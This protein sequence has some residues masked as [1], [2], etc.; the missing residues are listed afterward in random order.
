[1]WS[2]PILVYFGYPQAH[3]DYALRAVHT[4]LGI[5]EAVEA[6]NTGLESAKGITLAV[7]LGIHTGRVVVGEMGGKGRQEQLALGKVPNVASR[8]QGLPEP[9]TLVISDATYRLVE[10]YFTS[11]SLGEHTLRGVSQPLNIYSW[12]RVLQLLLTSCNI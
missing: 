2:V 5:R 10:G 6:L 7:R 12:L 8:I 4:G 9:K 1:M 11:E 3:E